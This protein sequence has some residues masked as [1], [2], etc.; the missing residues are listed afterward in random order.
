MMVELRR[1]AWPS[2]ARLTL[3]DDD[4]NDGV[5][6]DDDGPRSKAHSESPSRYSLGGRAGRIDAAFRHSL[7]HVAAPRCATRQYTHVPAHGAGR[8]VREAS[9][10]G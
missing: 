6:D 8:A 10:E 1:S 7:A 3:D 4:D 5:D 9:G 2:E